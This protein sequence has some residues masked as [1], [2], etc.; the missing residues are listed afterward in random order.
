MFTDAAAYTI[1]EFRLTAQEHP[2]RIMATV[3][4]ATTS[5]CSIW[6]RGSDARTGPGRAIWGELVIVLGHGTGKVDS[7]EPSIVGQSS[8]SSQP[9][10]VMENAGGFR[11]PVCR[12]D[13]Y[14]R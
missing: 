5:P 6:T 10:T 4:P 2:E 11:E 1:G 14:I 9:V 12:T 13:A 8:L 7:V 3:T